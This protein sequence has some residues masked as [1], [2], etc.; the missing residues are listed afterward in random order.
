MKFL[1]LKWCVCEQFH[2]YLYGGKFEVYTDNNPLTYILIS[3]KLDATGQIWVASLANY[4]FTIHYQSGKQNVEADALSRVKW[5]HDDAVVIKAILAKGFNAGTAIPHPFDSKLV[6]IGNVELDGVPKLNNDVWIR[7]QKEDVDIGP[8]VELVKN[9]HHLQYT[10]KEGDSSRMHMLVKYK[11]D[12]LLQHNLLYCRVRLKNH[13]SVI[14][15][16]VLPKTFPRS[17]TLALHDDYR[18]LGIEKTLGL[19]QERFFW[20]KMVLFFLF[21][22]KLL[23]FFI[24]PNIIRNECAFF[25]N[26]YLE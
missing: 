4:D 25:E 19:L 18:Y 21:K 24:F 9:G 10:C 11:Q 17:K 20:P 5:D 2:K 13:D 3:A 15:Q 8:G 6:H 1:A 22:E 26:H 16:F 14:N 7:E 12:L 23:L